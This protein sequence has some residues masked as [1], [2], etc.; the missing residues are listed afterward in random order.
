MDQALLG[1]ISRRVLQIPLLLVGISILT[2]LLMFLSPVDPVVAH[3]G[4]P[5]VQ[6]M[7]DEDIMK[8]KDE[9]GLNEPLH[10]RYFSWISH[11]FQGDFGRSHIYKRPIIDIIIE[12]LPATLYLSFVAYGVAIVLAILAALIVIS[13]E[14]GLIDR[15][16]TNTSFLLYAAPSFFIALILILVFSVWLGWLPSSRMVSISVP[17]GFF[18]ELADRIRHII[19]P[20]AALGMSH[21]ALFYG[22]LR[23]SLSESIKQDY[24]ITARAKGIDERT[25]LIRH[26]FRNSLLPFVTQL[27]LAIPWLISGSVVIET[28][29]AWPGI[30]RLT[31]DAAMKSD[32]MLLIG[33]TLFTSILVIIGNL[34]ADIAYA[35]IDP[36]VRYE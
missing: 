21:F 31:Y 20:A 2:F 13:R 6:K 36:R 7:S 27:G 34:L 3:F 18:A 9:W 17:P 33:L 19:L 23:S 4:L 5:I 1:Y 10:V 8:V 22:Y 30:G 16:I 32:F 12:K 25:I 11:L 15:I 28:I 29:F 26:A 24:I 14:G 35:I